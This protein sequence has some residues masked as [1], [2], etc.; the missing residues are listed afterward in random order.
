MFPRCSPSTFLLFLFALLGGCGAEGEPAPPIDVQQAAKPCGTLDE[1]LGATLAAIDD[2]GA[3]NLSA[4]LV[5]LERERGD[6]ADGLLTG[7]VAI[8]AEI[9]S[10]GLRDNPEVLE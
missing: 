9:W 1:Q 2:G 7:V 10:G 5:E 4:A 8:V 6:A 3:E